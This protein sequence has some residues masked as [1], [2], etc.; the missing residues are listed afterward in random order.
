MQMEGDLWK[1]RVKKLNL[2]ISRKITLIPTPTIPDGR[3]IQI[4]DGA[5][6]RIQVQINVFSKI[7]KH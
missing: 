4:S 2:L 5:I 3:I 6:T 7:N 1:D